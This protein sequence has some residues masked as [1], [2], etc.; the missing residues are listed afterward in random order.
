ME[1]KSLL[2]HLDWRPLIAALSS[3]DEGTGIAPAAQVDPKTPPQRATARQV[4]E[5]A[6]GL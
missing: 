5:A 3:W 2:E 6:P 1:T 4:Q